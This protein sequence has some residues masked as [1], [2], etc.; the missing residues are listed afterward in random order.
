MKKIILL[1]L[2]LSPVVY[3]QEITVL[4][5][6]KSYINQGDSL[7]VTI[8]FNN[9]NS[10]ITLFEVKEILP[11]GVTLISPN[12]PTRYEFHDGILKKV[13]KWQFNLNPGEI[14]SVSYIIQPN[15]LGEYGITPTIITDKVNNIAYESNPLQ[16]NVY[17]INNNL[18]E[19]GEN[20]LNCALD[21]DKGIADNTCSYKLDNLC[22]PDCEQD[23]DCGVASLDAL[24]IILLILTLVIVVYLISYFINKSKN[25][26]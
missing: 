2:I 13:Y 1:L 20:S 10:Y 22:D 26:P 8:I 9:P 16:F 21:C 12:T 17:C 11:E 15:N 18:C 19:E 24:T 7:D 14:A 6:S 23:P 3:A 5:E 4:K 25:S